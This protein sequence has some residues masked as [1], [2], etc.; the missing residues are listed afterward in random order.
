M[1]EVIERWGLP[2]SLYTDQ[3]SLQFNPSI[4]VPFSFHASVESSE[5]CCP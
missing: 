1:A 3:C 4:I 5:L 2:S